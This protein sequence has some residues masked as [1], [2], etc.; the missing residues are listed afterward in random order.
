[1][2]AKDV[3]RADRRLKL[4]YKKAK[5]A[6]QR[7]GTNRLEY[8]YDQQIPT[9]QRREV[10]AAVADFVQIN[11]M[12]GL[13]RDKVLKGVRGSLPDLN[14]YPADVSHILKK[15]LH[16]RYRRYDTAMIRYQDPTFDLKRVWV[17]R[18]LA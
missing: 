14:M 16:L 7:L 15:D 10:K 17:S 12:K 18:L 3:Y 2:A 5:A 11:G 8:F 1:M 6:G 13:T 9:A 4:N